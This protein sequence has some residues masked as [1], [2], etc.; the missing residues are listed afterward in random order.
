MLRF[1]CFLLVVLVNNADG[2]TIKPM[3]V[4]NADAGKATTDDSHWEQWRIAFD[5]IG[6][7]LREFSFPLR[8]PMFLLCPPALPRSHVR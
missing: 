8:P 1:P 3:K 7:C 2:A 5:N 6:P 4:A